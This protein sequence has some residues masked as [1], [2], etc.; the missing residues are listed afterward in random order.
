MCVSDVVF[1]YYYT[2]IIPFLISVV[3]RKSCFGV[4]SFC[5]KEKGYF[6]QRLK[7]YVRIFVKF[8]TFMYTKTGY[9][10][11][12]PLSIEKAKSPENFS[13]RPRNDF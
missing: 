2:G 9:I 7:E 4:E 10:K 13:V 8:K 11:M 3:S 6:K 1:T 5:E 12:N